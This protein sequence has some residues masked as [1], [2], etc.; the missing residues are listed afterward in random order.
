MITYTATTL[1]QLVQL[2]DTLCLRSVCIYQQWTRDLCMISSS[3]FRRQAPQSWI[4]GLKVKRKEELKTRWQLLRKIRW[5]LLRQT[6]VRFESN[7]GKRRNESLQHLKLRRQLASRKQHLAR[8]G[9]I[10]TD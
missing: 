4:K 10:S 1:T 7:E 5:S 3:G 6:L 8:Y 9:S 2:S